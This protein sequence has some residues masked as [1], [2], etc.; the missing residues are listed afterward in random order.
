MTGGV[1]VITVSG[2]SNRFSGRIEYSRS[3]ALMAN[4]SH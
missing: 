3:Y 4:R 2:G 1:V